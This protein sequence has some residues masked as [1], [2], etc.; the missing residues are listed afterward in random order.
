MR[1][2]C[3][4]SDVNW[5][6]M[7]ACRRVVDA[8]ME[9]WF[10]P[11]AEHS[12]AEE[13]DAVRAGILL[14]APHGYANSCLAIRDMDQRESIKSI[15]L[16]VLVIAGEKDPSTTVDAAKE[17]VNAIKGAELAIIDKAQH[18]LN[19]EMA[20]EFNE[21]LLRFLKAQMS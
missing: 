15:A 11:A 9:R 12:I 20:D 8:T 19:I 14:T 7:Q 13:L 3:G 2:A 16:P 18:L 21:I 4:M 1:P 17:I 10:S 5:F 6:S